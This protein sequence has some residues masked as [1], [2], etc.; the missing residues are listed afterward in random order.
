MV[1]IK[2]FITGFGFLPNGW[3]DGSMSNLHA[4]VTFKCNDGMKF[5]GISNRYVY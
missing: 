4:V 3:I 1:E 5:E 2:Y